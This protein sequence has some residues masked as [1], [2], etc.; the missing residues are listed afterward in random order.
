MERWFSNCLLCV[1]SCYYHKQIISHGKV[2]H[3]ILGM[4]K[5]NHFQSVCIN[6]NINLDI[7]QNE[8]AI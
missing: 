8:H 1:K 6:D 7:A 4:K 5:Q 2:E 3:N